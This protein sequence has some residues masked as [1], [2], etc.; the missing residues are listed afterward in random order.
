[1]YKLFSLI[2]R[3]RVI[4]ETL[5]RMGKLGEILDHKKLGNLASFSDGG[6]FDASEEVCY[7]LKD[8]EAKQITKKAVKEVIDNSFVDFI[9][10]EIKEIVKEY[11]ENF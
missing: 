11:G 3:Q 2:D 1:V 8:F 7:Y 6:F 9:A 10:Y 5:I 4:K